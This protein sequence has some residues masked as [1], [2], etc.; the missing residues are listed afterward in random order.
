M[1]DL[2]SR[3]PLQ[4]SYTKAEL[5]PHE[6]ELKASY[7]KEGPRPFHEKRK[8]KEPEWPKPFRAQAIQ[9]YEVP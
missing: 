5:D 7:N 3:A 4:F 6:I 8:P 1:G 9:R 2:V